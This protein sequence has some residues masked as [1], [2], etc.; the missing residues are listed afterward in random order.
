VTGAALI[1]PAPARTHPQRVL[2]FTFDDGPDETWT[3]LVLEQLARCDVKATFFMVGERVRAR[4]ELARAVSGAGHEI[5]LHCDR[6]IR[7]TE[8]TDAELMR[9]ARTALDSLVAVGARPRLWRAPWGVA[10][11]ASRR[12]AARLALRLVRWSIDTHDWRGDPSSRMLANARGQLA[13]GGAALMHDALGPG[14]R[15]AGC[16]NT[17]DLLPALAA[18]ARAEG[19]ALAPMGDQASIEAAA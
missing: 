8:L 3:P 12:V 18:A 11:D 14:A 13:G 5:Q 10:T 9:D 1:D 19:L 2:S 4:P 7:H 15:R 17:V 16:E 6:H